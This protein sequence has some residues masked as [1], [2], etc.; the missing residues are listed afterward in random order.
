MTTNWAGNITY[1]A[2]HWHK[3]ETVDQVQEAV[4]RSRRVRVLGS[5]HSF[6]HIADTP[7]DLISLEHFDPV[8]TID[9]ER[10]TATV[11]GGVRYGQLGQQLHQAGFMLHNLASLPHISIAGAC[12]TATHG[13]GDRNGNLATAV[14]ALE[15]VTASGEVVTLSREESGDVFDGA[16]VSLGGLGVVTQVTLD[17]TPA[18]DMCQDVYENL[19]LAQLE[20]HFDAITGSA[21]SVSLFTD[22]QAPLFNQV[23]L[24]RLVAASVA[25]EAEP[26]FFGATRA[27]R[28]LH[29]I[30][31]LSAENCTEQM[32]RRGPWH[33]RL[34]HFRMEFT[35][36]SGEELQ[37]E[38]L[39]P[40]SHAVPALRAVQ[41][42]R[43]Q[44]APLLLISEVRTIAAD[45]LWLS[46]CY[47]HACVAIHFT[48]KKDWPAVQQLLPRIEAALAPFDAR[49]HWGKLFTMAPERVQALYPRLPEFRNLMR[50]YDP[51]GKFRNAF[52]DSYIF[53]DEPAGDADG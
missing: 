6:N 21:Y 33:E 9:R 53:G 51:D 19:P 23:W 11:A 45:T 35:P 29:P 15:I 52:L 43:D 13:S 39:V 18:V 36:S 10:L 28:K 2:A 47:Q 5:R 30:G 31:S 22:W 49:P 37:T 14:A 41:Q 42:M 12:A 24:K 38:Y 44:I 40:R 25:P 16:V 50:R 8:V 46:P 1:S 48:W 20:T 17:I 26:E 7:G 3:P 4:R 32:G 27:T 34:P